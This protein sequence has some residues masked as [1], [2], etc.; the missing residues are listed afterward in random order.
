MNLL[1]KASTVLLGLWLAGRASSLLLP[2]LTLI[3]LL[4]T[5]PTALFPLCFPNVIRTM[6]DACVSLGSPLIC[7]LS[8]LVSAGSLKMNYTPG[9]VTPLTLWTYAINHRSC[10]A[11]FDSF[12]KPCKS[13]LPL[14]YCKP[15]MFAQ[16]RVSPCTY[17]LAELATHCRTKTVRQA[18][19]SFQ[20]SLPCAK[21]RWPFPFFLYCLY[22][23]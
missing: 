21:P 6:H 20:L 11:M 5:A 17:V 7:T 22:Q 9:T 4:W 23:F 18:S 2:Y 8:L 14:A 13:M 3:R 19:P 15:V 16:P 12:F 10:Q 1:F